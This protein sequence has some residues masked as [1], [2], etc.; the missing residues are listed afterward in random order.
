M[1]FLQLVMFHCSKY[2][3]HY[4]HT[5]K[6]SAGLRFPAPWAKHDSAPSK[7]NLHLL[8][9]KIELSDPNVTVRYEF[10][11]GGGRLNASA[12]ASSFTYSLSK[13]KIFI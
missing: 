9:L 11:R 12:N 4:T 10:S 2:N 5:S 7:T 13:S 8:K 6:R 1:S 3:K